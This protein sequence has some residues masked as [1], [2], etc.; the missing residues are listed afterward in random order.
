MEIEN[1]ELVKSIPIPGTPFTKVKYDDKWFVAFGK[2][3]LTEPLQT[4]EEADAA[5]SDNSWFRIM[6][7]IQAMI[8]ES[9]NNSTTKQN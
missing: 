4:E 9:K 1:E 6:Q 7:V 5:A 8:D 2:Y 3:R